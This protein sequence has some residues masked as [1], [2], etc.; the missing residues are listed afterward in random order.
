[1][2]NQPADASGDSVRR[3][4]AGGGDPRRRKAPR[5]ASRPASG[6]GRGHAPIAL[7]RVADNDFEL[8][9]PRGINEVEL[10]YEEGL[11]LW[12]AG[13]PESARD[14]LRFA[15]S[16]CHEN[17]WAHVALGRIALQ[18]F[19]DPGLARGHFGYAVEL[20]QRALPRGFSGRL[21]RDRPNNRPFY[22]ALEGLIECL[23][24]MGRQGEIASLRVELD[25]LAKG[26]NR[27]G[28]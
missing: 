4:G 6:P 3:R 26:P 19:H 15:L 20:C 18:E 24:A 27:S 7:T 16:A 28:P 25:R 8:V 2:P 5:R 22:D 21:P 1:M 10:D 23:Q 17:L 12:K 14:A 11:E 13:D 9:H